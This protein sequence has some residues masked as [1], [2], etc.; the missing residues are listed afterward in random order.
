MSDL[1]PLSGVKRKSDLR[2]V[3]SVFGPTA[4]IVR[5]PSAQVFRHSQWT[6]RLGEGLRSQVFGPREITLTERMEMRVQLFRLFE[7]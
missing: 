5:L 1:S 4:D 7:A 3:R 2:A 6:Q